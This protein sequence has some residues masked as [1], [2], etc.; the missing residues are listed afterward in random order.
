MKSD[1]N[2]IILK[3]ISWDGKMGEMPIG[4]VTVI[5]SEFPDFQEAKKCSVLIRF[6]LWSEGLSLHFFTV[7][8]EFCRFILTF[9]LEFGLPFK[10]VYQLFFV[11]FDHY[12]KQPFL[13]PY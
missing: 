1:V 13:D 12:L 3:P 9:S 6:I 2:F 8:Q 5:S 7:L 4:V 11:V 10:Q